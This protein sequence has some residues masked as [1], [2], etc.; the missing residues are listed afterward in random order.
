MDGVLSGKGSCFVFAFYCF[1]NQKLKKIS[2]YQKK[3]R[4]TLSDEVVQGWV[5]QDYLDEID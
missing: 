2:F 3:K 4:V 5:P 1:L